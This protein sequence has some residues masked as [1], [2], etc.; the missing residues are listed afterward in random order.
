M[1]PDKMTTKTQTLVVYPISSALRQAELFLKH[2][3]SITTANDIQK[4]FI[5]EI[6][7]QCKGEI[8]QIKEIE[9]IADTNHK[10]INK[11]LEDRGFQIKLGP[12]GPGGFGVASVLD[13]S[14]IHI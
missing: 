9:S 11:W 1:Q 5:D 10:N 14:L 8:S 4:K 6:H 7:I 2:V 13:L 3:E 12:F